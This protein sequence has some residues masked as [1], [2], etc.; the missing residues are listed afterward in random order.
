MSDTGTVD[1]L[2]AAVAP[3]RSEHAELEQRLADP[4][5]HADPAVARSLG[6][7]YAELTG[8]VDAFHAWRQA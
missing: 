7:R 5:V 3:L 1:A 8:V 4:A 6:R 2:T